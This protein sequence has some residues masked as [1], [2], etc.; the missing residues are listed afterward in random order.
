MKEPQYMMT[1]GISVDMIKE[2]DEFA[3]SVDGR[4]LSRSEAIR[5]LV[6]MGLDKVAED[7]AGVEAAHG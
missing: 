2:V 7:V 6:R 1:F 4:A 5:Q 3:K